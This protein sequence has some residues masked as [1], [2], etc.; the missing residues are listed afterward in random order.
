MSKRMDDALDVKEALGQGL[1][2]SVLPT[3]GGAQEEYGA[4]GPN[5]ILKPCAEW[6]MASE[7]TG[8]RFVCR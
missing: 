5:R 8:D 6:M 7:T 1:G 4:D 2:N 3:P